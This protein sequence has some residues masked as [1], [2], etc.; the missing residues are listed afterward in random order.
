M[1]L[2]ERWLWEGGYEGEGGEA[3]MVMRG[4]VKMG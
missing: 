3:S 1:L 4:K 2:I